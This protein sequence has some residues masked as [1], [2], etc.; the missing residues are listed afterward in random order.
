[1]ITHFPPRQDAGQPCA[2]LLHLLL[3]NL[4]QHMLDA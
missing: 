2:S 4:L 3:Q 1:M